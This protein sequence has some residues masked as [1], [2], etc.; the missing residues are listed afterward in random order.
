MK[1]N[2]KE[3]TLILRWLEQLTENHLSVKTNTVPTVNK[4]KEK[5]FALNITVLKLP[6][7]F[8]QWGK[9]LSLV[10]IFLY[11]FRKTFITFLDIWKVQ[12][13]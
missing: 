6:P 13:N 7:Q 3:K 4:Q 12:V 11:D 2:G 10:I 9:F 8:Q 5:Q 1:N